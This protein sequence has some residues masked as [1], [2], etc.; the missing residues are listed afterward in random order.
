MNTFFYRTTPA[1]ASEM[2]QKE[3]RKKNLVYIFKLGS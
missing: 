2:N 1:T 3:K